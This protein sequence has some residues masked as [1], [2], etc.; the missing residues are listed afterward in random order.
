MI[1]NNDFRRAKNKKEENIELIERLPVEVPFDIIT[2]GSPR[3]KSDFK[4]LESKIHKW[5]EIRVNVD[6]EI[7]LHPFFIALNHKIFLFFEIDDIKK[8]FE[9]KAKQQIEFQKLLD[10]EV[11]I[12]NEIE[13]KRNEV[14][15]QAHEKFMDEMLDKMGAPVKWIGYKSMIIMIDCRA[16]GSLNFISFA[17]IFLPQTLNAKWIYYN[18]KKSES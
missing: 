8:C 11:R 12:L 7:F 18:A 14:R 6:Q 4:A 2:I 15:K 17:N 16:Y 9:D 13:R 1:N 3:T 5:K 10:E